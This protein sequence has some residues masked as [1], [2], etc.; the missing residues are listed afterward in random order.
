MPCQAPGDNNMEVVS[1]LKDGD[2]GEDGEL[3]DGDHGEDGELED[4]DPRTCPGLEPHSA[5]PRSI[6]Q[7]HKHGAE[8]LVIDHHRFDNLVLK[9]ASWVASKAHGAL[10]SATT[11]S[12]SRGPPAVDGTVTMFAI[13]STGQ[14]IARRGSW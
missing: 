7:Q 11:T 2:H 3:E 13:A 4:G 6:P 8:N 5:A 1:E 12:S 14:R 9:V 10:S